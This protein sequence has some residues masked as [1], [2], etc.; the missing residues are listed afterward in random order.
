MCLCVCCCVWFCIQGIGKRGLA[1]TGA[2]GDQDVLALMHGA[3]QE[4]G[5][6]GSQDAVGH[7]LIQANDAHGA[8]AQREGR[9]WRGRRQD[10]L[11]AFAGF[12]Q[13]GGQE[14]LAAMH[15]RTDMGGD[16]ADISVDEAASGLI[17]RFEALDTDSTGCFKTWDGRDHPF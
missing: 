7:I 12:R 1:G 9:P 14:R 6:T 11:E 15:L 3:A 2:A 10:A 13:F 5:L 17:E 8:L 4:L 16:G